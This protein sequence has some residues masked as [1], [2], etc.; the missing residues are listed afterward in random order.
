M[1]GVTKRFPGVLALDDVELEVRAG[2]VHALVGENGAGKSTLMAIAAG[3]LPPDAGSVE[4]CGVALEGDDPLEAARAGLAVVYQHPALLPD[5]TVR[6][7]LALALPPGV[8]PDETQTADWAESALARAGAAVH[9]EVRVADL[10]VADRHLVE[11]AKALMHEPRL[12]ILDEPTEPLNRPEIDRLFALVRELVRGGTA[13][14]YISHR[15]P[16]V[17]AIANR[18]TVLRDGRTQGTVSVDAVDEHEIV[19][20]IVGRPIE[21]AFPPK[22]PIGAAPPLLAVEG[23]TSSDFHDITFSVAAGEIVGLAGIDGNGQ[24]ELIRAL[25]GLESVRGACAIGG[26]PVRLGSS[27]R[28]RRAGIA[29]VPGD[30]HREGAF[31]SLSVR[32]NMALLAAERTSRFGITSRRAEEAAIEQEIE[33]LRVRTAGLDVPM[34]SLSGGNQQKVVLSRALLCE[35]QL[36]LADEPTQGVDAGARVEMYAILRAAAAEGRGVLVLSSDALELAGLCDRVLVMSRGQVVAE[37]AGEELTEEAITRTA[38]TAT[39][40]RHRGDEAAPAQRSSRLRRFAAGDYSPSLILL[41]AFV[42]LCAVTAATNDTFLS[43][44]SL[45]TMLFLAAALAFVSMGQLIVVSTAGIDLSVGPLTGLLVVVASF[46]FGD[47][48]GVAGVVLGLL[49]MVGVAVAVGLLNGLLFRGARINPVVATLVTFTGIQGVALLLRP[50][51]DGVVDTN[52]ITQLGTTI[53]AVPIA[54]IVAAACALGLEIWL[55]RTRS[56]MALRAVGSAEATAGRIG[57]RLNATYLAAYVGCA[58]LTAAGALLVVA[59]VG[60]GDASAGET[61]TFASITAVVLGGA[62]VAGGRAS[63]IGALLGAL[64]IQTIESATPF[65]DL[66]DA[67]SYWLTGGLTLLAVAAYSRARR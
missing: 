50:T 26:R 10:S 6:E 55:R 42:A 62:A 34:S 13:V 20:R 37:L 22:P 54:F 27:A 11:I 43:Q 5:L 49:A 4:I 63:F 59:Q 30:R 46:C 58:V 65:L 60:I 44:R 24:K 29:Y 1:V 52:L 67:S 14:V 51:A 18:L 36:L 28:A 33:A 35:P 56:G 9:P 23:L 17:T 57:V 40:L 2:E 41:V 8:A 21:A 16:E 38:L 47:G 66:S 61:F 19:Q 45:S 7:N 31:L 53:G 3:A 32:E 12:L 64:L 15:I 25:A 48:V 39:S